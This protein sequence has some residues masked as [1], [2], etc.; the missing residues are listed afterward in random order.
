MT[1]THWPRRAANVIQTFR[2]RLRGLPKN[3]PIL[4]MEAVECGAASLAMVLA[5]HGRWM[6]LEELRVACGVSRDGSK[7]SNILKAARCQGMSILRRHCHHPAIRVRLGAVP[8]GELL[9]P[10][11]HRPHAVPG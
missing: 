11:H 10:P 2:E 7:A 5:Y 6:P 8:P 4:Q 9:I 1:P 3:P